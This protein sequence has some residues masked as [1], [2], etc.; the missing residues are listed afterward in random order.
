MFDIGKMQMVVLN[1]KLAIFQAFS[2]IG[3]HFYQNKTLDLSGKLGL[4]GHNSK[5]MLKGREKNL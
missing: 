1:N 2:Q 3:L 4:K 5:K